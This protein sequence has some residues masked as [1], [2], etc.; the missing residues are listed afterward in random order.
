MAQDP[1]SPAS[2]GA[3]RA[4]DDAVIDRPDELS[5][6]MLLVLVDAWISAMNRIPKFADAFEPTAEKSGG[7]E[8]HWTTRLL[9]RGIRGWP[10]NIGPTLSDLNPMGWVNRRVISPWYRRRRLV[11]EAK[12]LGIDAKFAKRFADRFLAIWSSGETAHLA[13]AEQT[14][15]IAELLRL[16]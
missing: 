15:K 7:G 4:D 14:Q 10:I 9:W 5:E 11:A 3:K 12:K 8:D 16:G 2:P 13:R 6:R 1:T